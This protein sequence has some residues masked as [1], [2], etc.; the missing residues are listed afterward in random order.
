MMKWWN[1]LYCEG[2]IIFYDSM[3]RMR[4]NFF[5]LRNLSRNSFYGIVI[6]FCSCYN[7]SCW[8]FKVKDDG[9]IN[10]HH[11]NHID[12]GDCVSWGYPERQK[13]IVYIDSWPLNNKGLDCTGP[14]I[15]YSTG[16]IFSFSY[17]FLNNILFSLARFVVRV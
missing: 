1:L 5:D 13:L 7:H 16:N 9:S 4:N 6:E 11:F 14:P 8:Y 17:D 2:Q 15:Q 10:T 12:F 3:H